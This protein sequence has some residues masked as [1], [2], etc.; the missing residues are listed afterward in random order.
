MRRL[1]A[2]VAL[3]FMLWPQ[4]VVMRCAGP[5]PSPGT[6][7]LSMMSNHQHGGPECPALMACATA[8]IESVGAAAPEDAS[9]RV[10]RFVTPSPRPPLVA[11][12]TDEPPPPRRSA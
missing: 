2:A 7:A 4:F 11:V 12:L 1:I 6:H 8:M 5:A 3:V 10:F 9:G